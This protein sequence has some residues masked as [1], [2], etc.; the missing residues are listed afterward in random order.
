MHHC[1]GHHSDVH[2]YAGHHSAGH[3]YAECHVSFTVMLIC[4]SFEGH[5]AVFS[6]PECH[7]SECSG[8]KFKVAD[9]LCAIFAKYNGFL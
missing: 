7:N 9:T 5:Y 6:Y 2:H 8:T 4:H 1:A 3:N